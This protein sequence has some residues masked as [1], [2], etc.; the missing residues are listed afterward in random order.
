MYER[1]VKEKVTSY[2]RAINSLMSRWQESK[3]VI[4]LTLKLTLTR[5]VLLESEYLLTTPGA[6]HMVMR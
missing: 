5:V 1:Y 4:S 3:H 6:V 2:Q